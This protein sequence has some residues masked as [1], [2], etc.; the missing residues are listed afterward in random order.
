MVSHQFNWNIDVAKI[1]TVVAVILLLILGYKQYD[2]TNKFKKI[3]SKIDQID[4]Q[5][6]NNEDIIQLK[7]LLQENINECRLE[8]KTNK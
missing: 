3:E 6:I 5:L 7:N 8:W 2:L 1:I 4:A